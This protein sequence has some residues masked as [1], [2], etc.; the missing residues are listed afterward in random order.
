MLGAHSVSSTDDHRVRL[1]GVTCLGSNLI[2]DSR[3]AG[4]VQ[5]TEHGRLILDAEQNKVFLSRH[6]AALR[7]EIDLYRK[8]GAIR[9]NAP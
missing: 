5:A 4:L 1:P 2:F 3:Q 7:Q 9:A 8:N 6:A